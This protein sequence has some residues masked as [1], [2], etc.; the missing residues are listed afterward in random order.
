MRELL[1]EV[2]ETK[3]PCTWRDAL[4]AAGVDPR[5]PSE[6]MLVCR[7]VKNM[8]RAGDLVGV[9]RQKEPGSRVWRATYEPKS[10]QDPQHG[11]ADQ[12]LDELDQ[13]T[14]SWASFD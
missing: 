14:R 3:A 6:V 5:S 2:F 7:T 13:V 4:P 10:W 1:A 9:G 8:V 11:D 12:A